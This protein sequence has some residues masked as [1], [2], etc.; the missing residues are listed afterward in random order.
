MPTTASQNTSSSPHKNKPWHLGNTTVRSP[1]RLADALRVLAASEYNG[2][3]NSAKSQAGFGQ[4]LHDEGFLRSVAEGESAPWNGRKWRAAMYQLGFITPGLVRG[5]PSGQVDIRILQ[6]ADGLEGVSGR[7]YEVTPNGKRLAESSSEIQM[8]ECFLRSLLAYRVPS[9][10][11]KRTHAGRPFSPLRITLRTMLELEAEGL[12]NHISFEEMASLVQFTKSEEAVPVLV[13]SIKSYREERAAHPD[14]RKFDEAFRKRE[15]SR[16]GDPVKLASLTD[17]ADV[18]FRYMRA[19]GLIT[20]GRA[21]ITI[22][23]DKRREVNL[24]IAQPYAWPGD[25]QYLRRLWQGAALPT[26]DVSEAAL[27]IRSLER[28]LREA[29]LHPTVPTLADRPPA[30]LE[31]IR[32]G[33]EAQRRTL[34]EERFAEAQ[35]SNISGIVELLALMENRRE[36][37]NAYNKDAPAYLEWVFWRAFLAINTLAN[38]PGDVRQFSVDAAMNPRRPA[39]SG[40]P[41]MICEFD[42]YV[43]VVEVTLTENS[44]QEAVE[45]E[46]VRR[47][48]AEVVQRFAAQKPVYGLFIAPRIDTNT[49]ETFGRGNFVLGGARVPLAIVPLTLAQFRNLFMCGFSVDVRFGPHNIRDFLDAA[50]ASRTDDGETWKAS[51]GGSMKDYLAR[52]GIVSGG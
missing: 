3:W 6:A 20:R 2:N 45:G 31:H 30:D 36:R 27:A 52:L 5:L 12:A 37:S 46:P 43:L 48:V 4:L 51:I 18:N 8:E 33:L 25:E 19:T 49:A 42:D 17:Y 14:K 35:R 32:L 26:D 1:F 50:L 34:Q 13:A 40:K 15:R 39:S 7:Q 47:H 10:I 21:S 9:P 38:K 41:D 22:A 23:P 16:H 11:E 24:I 28:E 44:R 29:G